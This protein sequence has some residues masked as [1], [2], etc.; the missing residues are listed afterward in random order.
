ML[1]VSPLGSGGEGLY[2]LELKD[3]GPQPLPGSV[4]VGATARGLLTEADATAEDN[5]FY[6]AYHVTLKANEKL[7]ITMVSNEVDS[8]LVVGREQEDGSFEVLES[9][10][11]SLSDSH[12]KL[13]WTAPSDGVYEVRAGTF[14][15][16]QTGAY[17]LNVEK[18]P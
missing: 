7:L 9:D 15:Q 14:Q 16:G 11:D 13:E 3:R 4:L 2:A 12:A 6:D 17:A 18:Q 8:L 10:D 5:S 1:R